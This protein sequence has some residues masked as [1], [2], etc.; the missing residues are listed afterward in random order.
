MLA[1][2]PTKGKLAPNGQQGHF[3]MFY[4][5][6]KEMVAFSVNIQDLTDKLIQEFLSQS[7]NVQ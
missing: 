5:P 1:P 4:H 2:K 7:L 3:Q 6:N